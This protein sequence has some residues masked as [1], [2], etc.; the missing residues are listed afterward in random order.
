MGSTA[1]DASP[2]AS[3]FCTGG[4]NNQ[5]TS[6][7]PGW[8]EAELGPPLFQPPPSSRLPFFYRYLFYGFEQWGGRADYAWGGPH[9]LQLAPVSH[10]TDRPNDP[11]SSL[12]CIL[13]KP[14]CPSIYKWY[15]GRLFG[16]SVHRSFPSHNVKARPVR[17]LL[18]RLRCI[19]CGICKRIHCMSASISRLAWELVEVSSE[20]HV[21]V[22]RVASGIAASPSRLRWGVHRVGDT[23]IRHHRGTSAMRILYPAVIEG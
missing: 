20:C 18:E 21:S 13:L 22:A 8:A 17:P 4:T 6:V 14:I 2:P 15:R 23:G 12:A 16:T 9:I 1:T 10:R 5:P 7:C 11:C 3:K 19:V